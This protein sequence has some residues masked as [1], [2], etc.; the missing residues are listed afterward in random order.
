MEKNKGTSN[1][2]VV[3][4]CQ[5]LVCY[6]LVVLVLFLGPNLSIVQGCQ[7]FGYLSLLV[8]FFLPFGER[9]ALLQYP[10]RFS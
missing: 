4:C 8:S 9:Q 6:L 7:F 2:V 5:F 3:N 1:K 10:S